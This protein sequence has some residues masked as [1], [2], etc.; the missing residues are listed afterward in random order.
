MKYTKM[1][2]LLEEN[3]LDVG[4]GEPWPANILS[5]MWP[6]SF[7]MGNIQYTC[8][9][10]FL[11][12]L[13]FEKEEDAN[14][15]RK[16]PNFEARREGQKGNGW[17]KAQ[18][19]YWDGIEIDR[20]SSLYYDIVYCA[21]E[22]M[23]EQNFLFRVALKL[24]GE[25]QLD[26]SIGVDDPTN[27]ILTRQ[28]FSNFLHKLREGQ[29]M[30][31][32]TQWKADYENLIQDCVALDTETTNIDVKE[33]EILQLAHTNVFHDEP[34]NIMYRSVKPIPPEAS[35]VHHISNRMIRGL[36]TFGQNTGP[37]ETLTN[38]DTRFYVAHNAD[39]DK[40]VLINSCKRDGLDAEAA[41]FENT[42]WICTWRLAKAV[43]GV[44]YTKLQYNLSYLRYALD[45]DV[46]DDLP[47][48]D[49]RADVIVCAKLFEMLVELAVMDKKIYPDQ[50]LGEQLY[51]LCWAPKKVET[52]PFGKYKGQKLDAI[53][54]DF[55]MWAI[56]NLDSL[57]E[58]NERY[59]LDLATSVAKVLETRL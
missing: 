23:C 19:L 36:P 15:I 12:S 48:H 22:H 6:H 28:D 5:N 39:Y 4:H 7:V 46:P 44:D 52:W 40:Q 24:T 58:E 35:A 59:D 2:K 29:K 45:L 38:K 26:H 51:N 8:M 20:Q 42:Q 18:K 55:Y 54:T 49:G 13:K 1:E 53:P 27:T 11:Q 10:S 57:K 41:H 3:K 50:D 37:V 17:K 31:T 25:K 14:R 32:N 21:F 30:T 56:E 43:L 47:A 16:L 33:A 34:E 9:E